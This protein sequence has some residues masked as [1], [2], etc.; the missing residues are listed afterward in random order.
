ML[1]VAVVVVKRFAWSASVKEVVGSNPASTNTIQRSCHSLIC[2]LSAA[3]EKRIQNDE[4]YYRSYA[5]NTVQNKNS[6]GAK[7]LLINTI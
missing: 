4:K 7:K 6:L 2:S 3:W 1:I 5:V